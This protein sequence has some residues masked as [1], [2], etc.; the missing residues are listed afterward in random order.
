MYEISKYLNLGDFVTD[1][2]DRHTHT[3]TLR[4]AHAGVIYVCN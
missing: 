3:D 4:H 2:S 1:V